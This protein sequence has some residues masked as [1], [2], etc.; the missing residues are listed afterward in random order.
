MVTVIGWQKRQKENGESFNVLNLQG[1]L[2]MI[3][4]AKS[5]KFYATARKTNL[6][7]TFDDAICS[8]MVG[9]QLQGTIEKEEC[10]LYEYTIPNSDEKVLLSHT[11]VYN[12][13][14][15]NVEEHVF[16]GK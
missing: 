3:K 5:G 16:E 14:P 9:Q 2:E 11:Y 4:S 6:V 10:E 1:G 15:A 13:E 7:C 12:P 8:T